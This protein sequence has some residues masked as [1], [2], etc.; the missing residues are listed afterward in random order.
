MHLTGKFQIKADV[1]NVWHQQ[2][3]RK[4]NLALCQETSRKRKKLWKISS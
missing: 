3:K 4:K 2:G 1:F